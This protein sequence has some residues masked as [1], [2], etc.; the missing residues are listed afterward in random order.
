MISTVEPRRIG[1]V[2]QAIKASRPPRILT[3]TSPGPAG[4][5]VGAVRTPTQPI[6]EASPGTGDYTSLHPKHEIENYP[7][8]GAR[9]A[10]PEVYNP[11]LPPPAK[12]RPQSRPG[13]VRRRRG[14][15]GR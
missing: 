12:P 11:P 14:R 3:S 2:D 15:P 9:R 1:W 6:S 8:E 10:C 7:P 5:R 13:V 4:P